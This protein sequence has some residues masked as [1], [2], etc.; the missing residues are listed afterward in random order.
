MTT[1]DNEYD[2]L[3]S[4]VKEEEQARTF[5]SAKWMELWSLYKTRPLRINTE[6][7][8]QSRL[9]DGRVFELIETVGSYIRNALF[10]SDQWVTLESNSPDTADI[11]PLASA[12]FRDCLNLSNFK[13]E[14]R[15]YL[16][17]L[18][19]IGFSA[20]RVF[21]DEEDG[22]KFECLNAYDTYIESTRRYDEQ[23]SYS[24]R[25]V[26]LNYAE[27]ANYA[28][29]G[30]LNQLE[31][32]DYEEE[33]DKL[34]ERREPNHANFLDETSQLPSERMVNLTELYDPVEGTVIRFVDNCILGEEDVEYSP[35]L[36]SILFET[37]EQ[38]YGLSIIDSS[39]G[40]VLE[41]NVLMNRRLDNIAVSVDN[42][43]L[44]VD[45][46]ITNPKDIKARPGAVIAVGR[47]DTLTPLHPPAN[48]FNVT[49][50]EAAVL[51]TK[52]DRNIGVGA[53]VSANTYRSGERVTAREIDAVKDAGGNRLTDVYELIEA[54][55]ILPLLQRAYAVVRANLKSKRIVKLKSSRANAYDFFTVLPE[56]LRKDHSVKLAATQAVINRD[57]R[58][59][60]LQQFIVT[61]TGIEQFQP[62]IDYQNLYLDLLV[63]FGFD[64]PMRYLKSEEPEAPPTPES[65]MQ[66]M[67]MGAGDIGGAPM[68][69]AL[70]SKVAAGELPDMA[71]S[72]T[73]APPMAPGESDPMEDAAI[74]AAMSTPL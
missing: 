55:C 22:L 49:Y 63:N 4:L 60:Q 61:V 53:M 10:F 68:Q 66:A 8:W 35:W 39:I 2:F 45:D 64:E 40:L 74:T 37:P 50:Q 11:L 15:L 58:I 62:F 24:F 16:T 65:P 17:Q 69:E 42:M 36:I 54:N 23:F 20:I 72:M 31:S 7:G 3:E 44:F 73:G 25:T 70:Q 18:L 67:M 13:R 51:D 21:W 5:L 38:A 26:E 9:N 56:D 59:D 57:R 6:E 14:F 1:T 27:F 28:E 32:D 12:Y 46:G 52:I 33:F 34:A 19:L 48:N 29:A 43:W 41:N 47:Q 71:R 30:L